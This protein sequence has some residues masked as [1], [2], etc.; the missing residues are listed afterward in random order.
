MVA[1]IRTAAGVRASK[2]LQMVMAIT[3][4]NSTAPIQVATV[5]RRGAHIP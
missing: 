3:A 4:V 1:W 2:S 5:T